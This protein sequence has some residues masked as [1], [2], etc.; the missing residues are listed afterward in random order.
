M[1]NNDSLMLWIPNVKGH[2]KPLG[3]GLGAEIRSFER[4]DY[5]FTQG[6]HASATTNVLVPV[7]VASM[8]S[9]SRT[10]YG[11]SAKP[12]T[13]PYLTVKLPIPREIVPWNADPITVSDPATGTSSATTV[14]L[15]TMTILRY[16]F[17]ANDSP[18]MTAQGQ[19]TW[20]REPI[21]VG[22]ERILLLGVIAPIPQNGEDEHEHARRAFLELTKVVGVS[23]NIDFPTMTYT[24]NQPLEPGVVPD[25]LMKVVGFD[26]T[27]RSVAMKA[28]AD[29][30][31]NIFGKINDCKA[32]A[33]LLTP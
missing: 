1:Q 17:Q 25:D 6:I 27:I 28:H 11:L 31:F 24:R 13:K 30:F 23:R 14:R 10:K 5:D 29:T 9:L 32:P 7:K 4:A 3:V 8:L 20:K 26:A 19:P 21:E 22:T 16:D 33:V 15:S 2:S 18:Q 12:R